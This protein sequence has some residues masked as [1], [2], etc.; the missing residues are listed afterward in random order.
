MSKISTAAVK[1]ELS[2]SRSLLWSEGYSDSEVSA[3]QSTHREAATNLLHPHNP[4]SLLD[5]RAKVAAPQKVK[6]GSAEQ[7][8]EQSFT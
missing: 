5:L 2:V 8:Q 3:V 4:R 1:T 6:L 7:T